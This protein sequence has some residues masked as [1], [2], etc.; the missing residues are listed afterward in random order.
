MK[1]RLTIV[2]GVMCFAV[3]MANTSTQGRTGIQRN[4]RKT[5]ASLRRERR[6]PT[7][8]NKR[9][10]ILV[11]KTGKKAGLLSTDMSRQNLRNPLHRRV[12]SSSKTELSWIQTIETVGEKW[13]N[14]NWVNDYK[15]IET[16]DANGNLTQLV[17]QSWDGSNW[18]NKWREMETYDANGVEIEYVYQEW[19][20]TNWVNVQRARAVN[21]DANG[22]VLEAV[23][24]LW[25]GTDWIVDYRVLVTYDANGNVAQELDQDWDGTDWVDTDRFL[26]TYDA[27]GN[28]LTDTYQEWD[29]T[30][31]VNV[32]RFI[33][34]YDANGNLLTDT[35]QEWDGTNWVDFDRFVY[36]YDANGNMLSD[37]Y[38]MWDGTNWVDFDRFLYTYDAN[39]NLTQ[40]L[41][42][43]SIASN[44]ADF[45]RA[46][47]TN[48]A[49]GDPTEIVY[50]L[51]DGT[52]WTNDYRRTYMYT[53]NTGIEDD[54]T[55]GALPSEF[56]LS[57]YPNPFN[58][59]TTIRFDLPTTSNVSLHI[60]DITGKL[61]KSLMDN[62]KWD[63]GSYTIT[64]D[65]TNAQNLPAPSGLYLYRIQTE[66]FSQTR[67]C[68]LLK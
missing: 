8:V 6:M 48:N 30:N 7:A 16:Y 47:Y 18:V 25:D 32:D 37:T 46:I 53:Q 39:G 12:I 57:N 13:E 26:Y 24:E 55:M 27:N 17:N 52:S 50:H 44:W 43:I 23:V 1:K 59:E 61:I 21:Q 2:L 65:G 20:G 35:Y 56:A 58:P 54:V 14:E 67:K 5:Q 15:E 11:K 40:F 36:T 9:L 62:R 4:V 28:M 45:G 49:A 33:S 66:S 68:T 51:W 10:A 34:T 64:W 38:Q 60:Y 42:Q 22:N 41:Y 63:A 31:W 3:M 29:G 19:D